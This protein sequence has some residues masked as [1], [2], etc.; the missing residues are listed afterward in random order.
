MA[1]EIVYEIDTDMLWSVRVGPN[2]IQVYINEGQSLTFTEECAK[3]LYNSLG[4]VLKG[5]S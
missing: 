2:L 1:K 3:A 4:S 5:G